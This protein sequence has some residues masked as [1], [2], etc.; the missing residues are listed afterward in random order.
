[1]WKGA[2]AKN[3][4]SGSHRPCWT[5]F[6]AP[7]TVKCIWMLL[8]EVAQATDI[9]LLYLRGKTKLCRKSAQDN[10]Y[11]FATSRIASLYVYNTSISVL[12][13][14]CVLTLCNCQQN[15]LIFVVWLVERECNVWL[16]WQKLAICFLI[17]TCISHV[18]SMRRKW[19]YSWVWLLNFV[20]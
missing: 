11:T 14:C 7:D 12:T 13:C 18:L 9:F 4:C 3:Y 6:Y 20:E 1:M 5:G 10:S 16:L 15:M 17:Y 19:G 8:C 2:Q